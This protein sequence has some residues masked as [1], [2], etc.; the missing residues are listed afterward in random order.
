MKLHLMKRSLIALAVAAC[1]TGSTALAAEADSPLLGLPNPIVSY[2]SYADT[3]QAAGF[4]PLYLTKG[5][6]YSLRTMSVIGHTTADLGFRNSTTGAT[7]RVR[8]ALASAEKGMTDISGIY[9]VQWNTHYLSGVTVYTAKIKD[10]A[11]A[12]HWQVGGYLFS[13][14]TENM[15]RNEFY[16]LLKYQLVDASS[17]YYL[18]L[19][20]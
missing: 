5:S 16:S 8:T 6:G 1:L 13:A 10:R 14:Q 12:A 18:P 9:S 2:T 20:K 3:A 7:V 11:Y 19:S 17:H 4:T 15:S